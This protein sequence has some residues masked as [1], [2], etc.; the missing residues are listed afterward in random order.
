MIPNLRHSVNRI[1]WFW[2]TVVAGALS[3]VTAVGLAALLAYVIGV[4]FLGQ[5]SL[6]DVT[7]PLA[8]VG[9]L[10]LLRA[11]LT[12]LGEASS[13]R[14]ASR[15]KLELRAR[16][17][18]ALLAR[19]PAALDVERSGE[20]ATTMVEGIEALDEYLSQYLPQTILAGLAPLIILVYVFPLDP[21]SGLVLLL[22]APII[23]VFMWLIGS[24]AQAQTAQRWADLG[25]MS[26]HFLDTLQ[27]ITT[28]KLFGRSREQL[29]AVA[30]ISRRFGDLTMEVLRVAFL[31][32]LILELVAS[33]GTA[34]LA[35]EIALRLLTGR[36]EFI[37]ALTLLILAPEFYL[38]LRLL[39]QRHHAAMAG[40][41][42]LGRIGPLLEA[43]AP[44]QAIEPCPQQVGQGV[45]ISIRNLHYAY[46]EGTRPALRGVSLDLPAGHIVGLSGPNGAGKST[47]TWLLLDFLQP[48]VGEIRVDGVPLSDLDGRA[49]RQRVA[50]VSQHP[51]LFAGSVAENIRLARPNA[52][53]AEV[54][55]VARE[56]GAHDFIVE[57][58]QG[59]QTPI[60][61]GGAR[62][63]GGQRQRLAIARALLK[64]ADLLILDEASAHLDRA[65]EA[66][67]Q[68]AL[69]ALLQGRSALIIAHSPQLLRVADHVE[70]IG[71][72]LHMHQVQE[73]VGARHDAPP[74]ASSDAQTRSSRQRA[75]RDAPLH[76][77]PHGAGEEQPTWRS[78]IPFALAILL[79]F[80]TVGS[81]IGLIATS[82]YLIAMAALM[83]SIAV[84][85][86]AIVGVRFF[87]IARG[88]FRY[89]ER[90]V[91]HRA[92][93]HL[94]ARLRTWFFAMIE[95]RAPAGLIDHQ[96]GDLLARA[97]GD[98]ETLEQ[99]YLRV[100]APPLVALLVMGLSCG[101]LAFFDP[102]LALALLILQLLAGLMLPLLIRQFS[103]NAARVVVEQRAG[104]LTT[105]VEAIQGLPDLLALGAEATLSQRVA[106]QGAVLAQ[107]QERLAQ[108]RGL[109]NGLFAMLGQGAA[110]AML[111][112]AIPL[113]RSGQIDGVMLGL[114][115][116]SALASFEALIPLGPALQS[117]EVS[118]AAWRRLVEIRA[119]APQISHEPDESPP[120]LDSSIEFSNLSF[121]YPGAPR[122]VL[123]GVSGRVATG[124]R[125]LIVGPSGAGKS[126]L[127][128]LLLRFWE[129]YQGSICIGGHD[130]RSYRSEDVRQMIGVVA[131]QTH[132]FNGTVEA[133]LRLARPDASRAELDR[134]C[135]Q[136]GFDQ[137]VARLPE[138]YATW[139]GERGMRLSGGER[140]RL[141]IARALLKDAPILILDEPTAHLDAVAER[142]VLAALATLQQ[143]RTTLL[144]S[145]RPQAQAGADVVV[146]LL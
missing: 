33:L 108:L 61:A 114:I 4:V 22:T 35:V 7:G 16:L 55:R 75:R 13:Q 11:G 68:Q 140:Q 53:D 83:P 86:V 12:W 59:Y 135:Q 29:E 143:G 111:I 51:A 130:L 49:W 96:G 81:S 17:V 128:N 50:W 8:G 119:T 42:A 52:S 104:L 112:L 90:Y 99:F 78:A 48:D 63:S 118:R 125:M 80:A 40:K 103:R 2:L 107:A 116:L 137:V 97:V 139:L 100:V 18:A 20:L 127:A 144:I 131:Q 117:L 138:G 27:G 25:R 58:P 82:A 115:A 10:A 92:T 14:L 69:P 3:A 109:S 15:V 136:A 21:L 72:H 9:G 56:A 106:T 120:P 113:V 88:L 5:A 73:H 76:I 1:P 132:L 84:L 102:G 141:A 30:A 93:F 98:V 6:S 45:A 38:P 121:S 60:G 31:S 71:S 110:V 24:H 64:Q 28:L 105:M 122:P 79:G 95:P 142:E 145:H 23:P 134:A 46:A 133:N 126:T 87:G 54:E 94:L 44:Q 101:L 91:A 123:Q 57:L 62:L 19:G 32:A 77:P 39:G 67:L 47:L 124:Q 66:A 41:E 89:A 26:A 146:Q 74:V 85:S 34:I 37:P 70:V 43:E 65:S 36:M 129:G